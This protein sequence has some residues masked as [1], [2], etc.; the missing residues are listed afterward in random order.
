M[1][2]S[3]FLF[4]LISVFCIGNGSGQDLD[5][6]KA[7]VNDIE[8]N[9]GSVT[10]TDGTVLTGLLKLNTKTGLL[11]YENGATSKSF[12]ARNVLGFSYFDAVQLKERRFLSISNRDTKPK[13]DSNLAVMKKDRQQTRQE[14]AIPKFYEIL[15]ECKTFALVSTVGRLIIKQSSGDYNN[16]QTP[17]STLQLPVPYTGASTTYSSNEDLLVLSEDG[18]LETVL[19][20]T[21][22]EVDRQVFDSKKVKGKVEESVIGKYTAPHYGEV[23]KYARERELKFKNRE[24]LIQIFEYYKS[25]STD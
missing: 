24:D 2:K 7:T 16:Q 11:G 19:E 5:L 21:S 20:I 14:L 18:T 1:R 25:L 9:E 17:G 6:D 4:I 15:V 12:T 8:W 3:Y 13:D 10:L 22:T 23:V